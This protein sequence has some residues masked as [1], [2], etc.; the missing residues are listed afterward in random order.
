MILVDTSLFIGYFRGIEEEPYTKL[1]EIIDN[2]IPFGINNYIYQELLQGAKSEWEYNELKGYLNTLP[3]Y[4]LKYGKASYENAA[5]M[6]KKCRQAGITV[7]STID[8]IIAETAVENDLYIL[9][10]D[11][12]F[13]NIF[14]VIKELKIYN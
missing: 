7:R 5:I 10:N 3:F 14:K 12:D 2:D 4:E 11:N 13:I 1:D 9:H 6:Y 8:L